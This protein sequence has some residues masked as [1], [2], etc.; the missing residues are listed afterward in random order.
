VLET[1]NDITERKQTEEKLR[2]AQR[3]LLVHAANLEERVA[4]RTAKLQD[5]V[6][7]LEHVSYSITHDMRAPLRAMSAFA[8]LM[9]E[10]K[11]STGP[12]DVADY[13]RKILA[14]STRLDK[15]IQDALHYTTMLRQEVPLEPVDLSKLVHELVVTYPNLQPDKADIHI[16]GSLPVVLGNESLLTQCFSNLLGNAVKFV[17]PGTRP[18]VS[19]RAEK[20]NGTARIWIEDNGIGIPKHAQGRLFKM[21]QRLTHEYEGSGIGLA[22]VRKVVRRMGGDVG[23]ESEPHKGSR[24]WVE[25]RVPPT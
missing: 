2:E 11:S 14:A 23:A 8:S 9:L 10:G 7:E 21:F 16:E 6:N 3:K 5:M 12:V 19:L 17:E 15:L 22:I 24:F 1:N 13:S 18:Q 20:H 25:L 4:E